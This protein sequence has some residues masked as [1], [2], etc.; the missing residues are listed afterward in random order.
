[1][2][3]EIDSNIT[4]TVYPGCKDDWWLKVKFDINI[5]YQFSEEEFETCYWTMEL[6]FSFFSLKLF[7]M[8]MRDGSVPISDSKIFTTTSKMQKISKNRNYL[9]FKQIVGNITC[10]YIYR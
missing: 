8:L 7:A 2:V 3:I 6:L 4:R 5:E 9:P 1:M 10:T